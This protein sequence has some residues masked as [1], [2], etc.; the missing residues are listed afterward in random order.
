MLY[1]MKFSSFIQK[2]LE[3]GRVPSPNENQKGNNK[4]GLLTMN[5]DYRQPDSNLKVNISIVQNLDVVLERLI[6]NLT[7][8]NKLK[9]SEILSSIK[10]ILEKYK[11]IL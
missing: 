6:Q 8:D 1:Q 4:N 5:T 11:F 9:Q 2:E 10:D 7:F 3:K